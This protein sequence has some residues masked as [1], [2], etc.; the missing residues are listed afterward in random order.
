MIRP[1]AVIEPPEK[2]AAEVPKLRE[3]TLR[4][5][6]ARRFGYAAHDTSHP[7][8]LVPV[9]LVTDLVWYVLLAAPFVIGFL[10]RERWVEVLARPECRWLRIVTLIVGIAMIATGQALRWRRLARNREMSPYRP[11]SGRNFP[12]P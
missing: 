6:Y 12:V 9:G 8:W 2:L 7:A 4:E 10:S 3:R 1:R 5:Q 11:Y